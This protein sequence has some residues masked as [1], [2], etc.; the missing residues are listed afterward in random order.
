MT[1]HRIFRMAFA[2]VYPLL[3]AKVERKGRTRADVDQAI[4]WLTGYDAAGL[5]DQLDKGTSY[6]AFFAE[7]PRMNPD[8][9]LIRGAVCGIRV[10]DIA[11]PVMQ[12]IRWLDKLVDEIAKGKPMDKILRPTSARTPA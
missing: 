12:Q 6:A 4:A 8:A 2:K 7:A 9:V 11:D 1:E 3:V 10:E 5:K